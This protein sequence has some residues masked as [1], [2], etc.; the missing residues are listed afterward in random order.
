[1]PG[2]SCS[3]WGCTRHAHAIGAEAAAIVAPWYFP[4][5]DKALEAHLAAIAEAVPDLA[6]YLY[7][8]PGNAKNDL[9]PSLSKR[10]AA[11]YPNIRGVKDSSKDLGRLQDYI[12]ALG[13]GYEVVV[14]TDALV[15]PALMMGATGV[16]S[17]VGNCFPAVM[18]ELYE[19]YMAGDTARA[20][21]LQ[22]RASQVRAALKTGPYITPYVEALR[23]Q[24]LD[25]GHVKAPLRALTAEEAGRLAAALER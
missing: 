8:I 6:L 21:E 16:V 2:A 13:P 9:K 20:T 22:Y 15:A 25:R 19:A 4:H 5:D 7:N 1:M 3:A 14:G 12:A 18:V 11:R 10:L 23:L 24:G 17:A